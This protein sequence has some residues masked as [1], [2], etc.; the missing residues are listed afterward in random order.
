METTTLCAD[1][2]YVGNASY[3]YDFA[4]TRNLSSML[5]PVQKAMR[6]FAMWAVNNPLY[7]LPLDDLLSDP[8]LS[9]ADRLHLSTLQRSNRYPVRWLDLRDTSPFAQDA[10]ALL[11]WLQA[12]E[13]RADLDSLRSD[14]VLAIA[15]LFYANRYERSEAW[16]LLEKAQYLGSLGVFELCRVMPSAVALVM[17]NYWSDTPAKIAELSREAA[18][19]KALVFALQTAN[20]QTLAVLVAYWQPKPD[21]NGEDDTPPEVVQVK[22]SPLMLRYRV[23][24]LVYRLPTE[25]SLR[26]QMFEDITTQ[27]PFALDWLENTYGIRTAMPEFAKNASGKYVFISKK[28]ADPR[29]FFDLLRMRGQDMVVP[30]NYVSVEAE[31]LALTGCSKVLLP[32][33]RVTGS[34]ALDMCASV[35]MS[36][37]DVGDS[38]RINGGFVNGVEIRTALRATSLK[39]KVI[40][41]TDVDMRGECRICSDR[42]II[43]NVRNLKLKSKEGDPLLDAEA[44]E[45]TLVDDTDLGRL[46]LPTV[47]ELLLATTDNRS[48]ENLNVA[49]VA[50]RLD[51]LRLHCLASCDSFS[52]RQLQVVGTP[53][54][55]YLPPGCHVKTV[56]IDS[57]TAIYG[58][59]IADTYRITLRAD[60]PIDFD[61]LS[62]QSRAPRKVELIYRGE[63]GNLPASL[64]GEVVIYPENLEG[65]FGRTL[66]APAVW[67]ILP[68]AIERTKLL[69]DLLS[70]IA[71][72]VNL[73]APDAR[74][75]PE[76]AAHV[77]SLWTLPE[78]LDF[79][80]ADWASVLD[81]RSSLKGWRPNQRVNVLVRNERDRENQQ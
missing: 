29:L 23:E 43:R 21:E 39:A 45:L 47:R 2:L 54:G 51:T 69:L 65:W 32:D 37:L 13:P 80:P 66:K 49:V 4:V 67:F 70:G 72:R 76:N 27:V 52:L 64:P 30:A 17:E 79:D 26:N 41:L 10:A 25:R 19:K 8:T 46:T 6:K 31:A 16:E 74:Y 28:A 71:A 5:P 20:R 3:L 35:S 40:E 53:T 38:L 22:R 61:A 55:C 62:G 50:P 15:R 56:A 7:Y 59:I 33:T 77:A 73:V 34:A 1:G 68:R 60:A 36:K 75:F 42:L 11:Y 24:T 9:N 12:N 81:F 48:V 44:I 58:S 14:Q 78:A 57:S 18:D 63:S